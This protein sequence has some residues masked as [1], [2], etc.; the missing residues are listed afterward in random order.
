MGTNIQNIG[1]NM[2]KITQW[3]ILCFRDSKHLMLLKGFYVY[4]NTI[5]DNGSEG[6]RLLYR[7]IDVLY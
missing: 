5:F 1:T 3:K 7:V 6:I 4:T 2:L